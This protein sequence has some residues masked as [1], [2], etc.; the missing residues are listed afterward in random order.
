MK[1]R[2][3]IESIKK[4]IL[5]HCQPTR[6]YI[7]G[8]SV[9][10]GNDAPEDIDIAYDCPGDKSNFLI[11]EDVSQLATLLKIDV[12]NIAYTEE[13]FKNRILDT[14]KVIWSSTKL[15]RF[16]DAL[17][18]FTNAFKRYSHIVEREQYYK[19]DGY[20]D[21]F[22]DVAVKRFEFT[23]EMSWKA[24]KRA[25]DYLG[26]SCKS[27]RECLKEAFNH[28]IITEERM[29]LEMLEQRNLS[30]H[31]YDEISID[32]IKNDLRNYLESFKQLVEN[33]SLLLK[34]ELSQASS[35]DN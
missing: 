19:E 11:K 24:C 13:R 3:I 14:G 7:F 31:I 6:I 10:T 35:K 21:V 18:N 5:K 9:E 29:W 12:V 32:E 8:S 28:K 20:G 27:P 17:L 15:L 23:F 25:L 33:L 34:Q 30:A 22:L 16:E 1:R 26:Y 2:E 4:I